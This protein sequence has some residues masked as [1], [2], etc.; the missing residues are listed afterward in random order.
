M[1]SCGMYDF[2]GEWAFSIGLPAKSGV[3]GAILTVVPGV[4]GICTWSPRLDKHGNSVRGI[5]FCKSLVQ[6]Y[7]FHIFSRG[8][9]SKRFDGSV[10]FEAGLIAL[11]YACGVGDIDTVQHLVARG[12]DVNL[13]D[14][15]GRTPL[16]LASSEGH[17]EVVKFLVSKGAFPNVKDRWGGTPLADAE[18]GKFHDVVDYLLSVG[19][20]RP[21][22]RGGANNA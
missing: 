6:T 1:Y 10:N 5:A 15:D 9:D 20:T 3:A 17:M 12:A 8:S 2:S 11:C 13:G 22:F 4:M 7:D 16:H 14:Y 19:A 21:E 18:R